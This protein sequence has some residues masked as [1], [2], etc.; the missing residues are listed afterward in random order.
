M[1][2]LEK[3]AASLEA[4]VERLETELLKKGIKAPFRGI[5]IKKHVDKD[6]IIFHTD[7]PGSPFVVVKSGG[8]KISEMD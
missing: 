1:T 5:I 7:A 8:E 2:G 6:D 3:K 4:N